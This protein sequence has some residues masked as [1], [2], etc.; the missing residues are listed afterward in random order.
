MVIRLPGTPQTWLDTDVFKAEEDRYSV[1][2]ADAR[3]SGRYPF[4]VAARLI[5]ESAGP[6]VSAAKLEERLIL[7]ARDRSLPVYTI[8][9][10]LRWDGENPFVSCL[11]ARRKDLNK[12]LKRNERQIKWRFPAPPPNVGDICTNATEELGEASTDSKRAMASL[13]CGSS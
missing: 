2:L 5:A 12:W 4:H 1:E 10:D 9:Q 8:G 13:K 6:G 7:A 3:K 11:E